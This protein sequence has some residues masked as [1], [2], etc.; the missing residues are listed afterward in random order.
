MLEGVG[1]QRRVVQQ[2]RMA[3]HHPFGGPR[4][5]RG[6]LKE[7]QRVA[8][9]LR[10]LPLPLVPLVGTVGG[11]VGREPAQP[12]QIRCL[13]NQRP[14]PLQD[15]I[16]GQRHRRTGV[17]GNRLDAGRCAV[18]PRRVSRHRDHFGILTAEER[19]DEIQSRRVEEQRPLTLQA[20]RLQPR[21]DGSSLPVELAIGQM[22][23]FGFAV[24]QKRIGSVVGLAFCSLAQQVDQRGRC[25]RRIEESIAG[26]HGE[27]SSVNLATCGWKRYGPARLGS[28]G[29]ELRVLFLAS[30]RWA[31]GPPGRPTTPILGPA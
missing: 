12:F 29:F 16:G 2:V 13:V 26:I 18:H 14:D 5:A 22:D 8:G 19:C 24:N 11:P 15:R 21:S 7:G 4:R 17:G 27:S 31:L 28:P 30:S 1:D 3:E 20:L 23:F 10:P 9:D 6:V 25:G